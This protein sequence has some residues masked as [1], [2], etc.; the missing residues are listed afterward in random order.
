MDNLGRE[1]FKY[2]FISSTEYS[3]VTLP[4]WHHFLARLKN[5]IY[6]AQQQVSNEQITCINLSACKD[7]CILGCDNT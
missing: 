5:L 2:Y 1:I 3:K 4:N 7:Y 6:T